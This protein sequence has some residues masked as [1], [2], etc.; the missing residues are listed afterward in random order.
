MMAEPLHEEFL[1]RM[2]D[3]LG[4]EFPDFNRALSEPSVRGIRFNPWKDIRGD[5]P[6]GRGD[7]VPW[8][9]NAYYLDPA[10]TAG[11]SILHEAGAFY[12]QEPGAMLPAEVLDAKPGESVLDL[13]S[14][15]GGKATQIGTAMKGKGLLVCNDPIPQRAKILSRN[16][17]R[18]GLPHT[19][20]TCAYPAQLA[21]QWPEAFDAVMADVPCSGEGM[22]RRD[23]QTRTEWTPAKAAGCA[24]RQREI[25]DCAARMVRAGGRL[26]Y[27]TCTY[28]PQ[29][30]EEN[31]EW[32]L[33]THPDF[34]AEAFS[35][36]QIS[37]PEG[38]F[39]CYPH[40]LRGEG[41]FAAL[42]R[43]KGTGRKTKQEP[44]GF[45]APM[46]DMRRDLDRQFPSFPE[47]SFVFGN[48]WVHF[49]SCPDLRGIRVLRAGLHLG[50]FRGKVFVP[51]HA[52]ALCIFPPEV[53]SLELSP[54]EA[55][56]Y[57]AGESFP[58]NAEGWVLLRWR[59]IVVG[60]G[61]G[62]GGMIKNHYPKGLRKPK[63]LL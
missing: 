20:V 8:A 9:E 56:R 1:T 37:A 28:N 12:I 38:M 21:E 50:E 16:I 36:P 61:K 27:S 19:A 10:S 58:S 42:F 5:V 44:S 6:E 48:T 34:V 31:A 7:P 40:R 46:P 2:R 25:L 51:D 62:S 15:P 41:Q 59:G 32:F 52:A 18:I 14:A 3:L 30:N 57:T 13:C 39:T 60:W 11:A 4:G 22:F 26:V 55:Q 24:L 23:P 63:L 29:E 35:L 53:K 17:E 33:Q 43:K 45:P 54:E 49:P 47:S